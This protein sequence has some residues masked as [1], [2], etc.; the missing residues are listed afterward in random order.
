MPFPL[1]VL[2]V[3]SAPAVRVR[4]RVRVGARVR[5]KVSPLALAPWSVE[6][7]VRT[8]LDPLD[9]SPL[10]LSLMTP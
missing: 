8:K 7:A 10:G 4:V 3:P 9:A 1:G 5:V 6:R 2:S